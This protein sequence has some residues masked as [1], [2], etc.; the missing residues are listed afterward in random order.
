MK[1]NIDYKVLLVGRNP[2]TRAVSAYEY[3]K[4]A[5]HTYILKFK[6]FSDFMSQVNTDEKISYTD[7]TNNHFSPGIPMGIGAF[8]K[9]VYWI[10][11][12]ET[13]GEVHKIKLENISQELSDIMG[14]YVDFPRKNTHKRVSSRHSSTHQRYMTGYSYEIKPWKHY[15]TKDMVKKIQELYKEDFEFWGYDPNIN[16]YTEE[17]WNL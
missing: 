4:A 11:G 13:M 12:H 16:P 1:D 3:T 6:D 17:P 14:F 8:T 7:D 5:G 9:Q 15:Y 10:K 2:F